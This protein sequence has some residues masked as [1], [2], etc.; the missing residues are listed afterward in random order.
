MYK[1]ATGS[2]KPIMSNTNVHGPTSSE[3]KLNQK[4]SP[5]SLK[6]LIFWCSHDLKKVN[7]RKKTLGK[8]RDTRGTWQ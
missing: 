2:T 4:L 8:K 7:N 6:G 1:P 3:T 5:S